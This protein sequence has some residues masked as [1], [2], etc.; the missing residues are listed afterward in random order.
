MVR[1]KLKMQR[2]EESRHVQGQRQCRSRVTMSGLLWRE[3]G[4]LFS[5]K[6]VV[7]QE[8][9]EEVGDREGCS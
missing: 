1:E 9:T 7:R 6:T 2:K 8:G 5:V 3:A 4:S